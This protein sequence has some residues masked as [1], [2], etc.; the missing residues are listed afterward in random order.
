MSHNIFS[1]LCRRVSNNTAEKSSEGDQNKRPHDEEEYDS[2]QSF[3]PSKVQKLNLFEEESEVKMPQALADQTNKYLRKHISDKILK[4]KI[5]DENPVPSNIDVPP[6][7]DMFIKDVLPGSKTSILARDTQLLNIQT[8]IH[9]AFSPISALWG[10]AVI[11]KD[12]LPSDCPEGVR[13]RMEEMCSTFE[14]IVA[15]TAQASNRTAY[16]RRLNL[17]ENITG[18]A[19]RAKDILH[20]N[21]DAFSDPKKHLFGEKFE[22]G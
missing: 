12:N 14:Q 18:D 1:F 21:E 17:V 8:S 22:K 6:K 20:E 3:P 13:A 16:Y 2:D 10:L 5:L 7:V 11:E 15:L 4:E 19:K 9:R